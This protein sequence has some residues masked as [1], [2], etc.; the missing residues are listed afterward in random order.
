[1][2]PTLEDGIT[3]QFNCLLE[4]KSLIHSLCLSNSSF[5]FLYISGSC[6]SSKDYYLLLHYNFLCLCSNFILPLLIFK[7]LSL[8]SIVWI[9]GFFLGMMLISICQII[10][11]FQLL[12]ICKLQIIQI[13]IQITIIS[14]NTQYILKFLLD[15]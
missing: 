1:M 6:F 4:R 15:F 8:S 3:S 11:T 2:T 10:Q 5:L 7:C 13:H 12:T 9:F 14:I